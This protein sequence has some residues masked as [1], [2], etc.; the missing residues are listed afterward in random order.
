M[1]LD[2]ALLADAA[3]ISEGK[4][5]ILGGGISIL[6]REEYPAEIGCV[7]VLQFTFHRSEA[8]TSHQIRIDFVDADGNSVMPPVEGQLTVGDLDPQMPRNL[9]IAAPAVIA[10]PA[11]PALQREGAYEINLLADGRHIRS[12]PL[13]VVRPA[14]P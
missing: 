12:I 6:W 8:G 14:R 1:D 4:T 10:F 9:P 5:Y 7:L 13:A 2:Y 3:Q 11:Y